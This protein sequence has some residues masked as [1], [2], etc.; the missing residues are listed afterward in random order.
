[1]VLVDLPST[2]LLAPLTAVH[3]AVLILV[4]K[5]TPLAPIIVSKDAP[6]R[7]RDAAV[8]TAI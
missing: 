3:T 5:D 7:A 1:V 8:K 2:L 6:A 4:A